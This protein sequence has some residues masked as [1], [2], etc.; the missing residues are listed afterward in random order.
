MLYNNDEEED[1]DYK[2]TMRMKKM[3]SRKLMRMRTR[4]M[5]KITR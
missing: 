5:M 2:N 3:I 1:D 4:I